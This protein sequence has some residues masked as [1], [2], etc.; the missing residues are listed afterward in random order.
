MLDRP[1][2]KEAKV[3]SNLD[4]TLEDTVRFVPL[5]RREKS[6]LHKIRWKSNL[7]RS[8]AC[9]P[10][11]VQHSKNQ[12]MMPNSIPKQPAGGNPSSTISLLA[13]LFHGLRN[14][15]EGGAFSGAADNEE[16]PQRNGEDGTSSHPSPRRN[17]APLSR[18]SLQ[19]IITETLNLLEEDLSDTDEES[20]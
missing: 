7:L 2:R 12:T 16:Q 5:R 3:T 10:S 9:S 13:L 14:L 17:N 1:I 19:A 6:S 4:W 18:A 8:P 15:R 11:V 20:N